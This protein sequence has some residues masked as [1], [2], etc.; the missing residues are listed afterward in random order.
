MKYDVVIGSVTL[1]VGKRVPVA[2]AY[3]HPKYKSN[4]RAYDISVLKL[5]QELKFNAKVQSIALP[6]KVDMYKSGQSGLVSGFGST[7]DGSTLSSL[8]K[9]VKVP[10]HTLATC[11]KFAFPYVPNTLC[12]GNYVVKTTACQ[13]SGK[14]I[15]F[16]DKPVLLRYTQLY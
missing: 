8:L 10:I 4:E 7:E 12:A 11:K 5:E 13:V 9:A 6:K 15:N 14:V 16:Y 1:G 2:K 3:N